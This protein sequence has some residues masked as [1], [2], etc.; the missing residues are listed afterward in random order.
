MKIAIITDIHHGPQSHT[1]KLGWNGLQVL[2]RFIDKANANKADLILDLGDHISD[3]THENDYR[4]ASEVATAFS[5]FKGQRIHIMGNHDVANLTVA[6]NEAIFGQTMHSRVVDLGD[7]RLLA[8][9]PGVK[10]SHPAGFGPCSA[11]L[12]W[13]LDNLLADERPAIIATHV[14]LSG[15]SMI[16]NFYFQN[17]AHQSTYPDHTLIREAVEKTGRAALWLSGHV[18][19]STVHNICG[20]QHITIQSMSERF[21]TMPEPAGAHADLEITNGEFSLTVH[22]EDP[23]HVRLPF[24]ASGERPWLKPHPDQAHASVASSEPACV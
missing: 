14:P 11:Q 10:M 12:N 5:R 3:S 16:G 24:R 8:W 20:V 4:V 13:L 21:T 2:E 1:K 17:E 7:M 23:F 9:Q 22:G 6:D 19:W 18:H 15:H